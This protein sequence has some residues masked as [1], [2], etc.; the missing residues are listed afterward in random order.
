LG[1][2]YLKLFVNVLFIYFFGKKEKRKKKKHFFKKRYH[3]EKGSKKFAMN[4]FGLSESFKDYLEA[5]I[6]LLREKHNAMYN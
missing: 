5:S 2:L 3:G 6:A 1:V 4:F